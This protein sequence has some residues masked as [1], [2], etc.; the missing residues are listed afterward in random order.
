MKLKQQATESRTLNLA[1]VFG[2]I[3]N[4]LNN[5]RDQ[6]NAV[7]AN[8]NHGSNIAENFQMVANTLSASRNQDAPTQ[9]RQAAQVLQQNGRGG[10]ANLYAGGLLEAAQRLVGKNGI[11]LDDVLPL[12]QGLLSGVQGQTQAQPG[13]GTLLDTLLPAIMGYASARNNGTDNQSAISNALNAALHGSQQTYPQPSPF[14]NRTQQAQLPRR[15]PGAA[16]AHSLLEGLFNSIR[17]L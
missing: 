7:D 14:G 17:N 1:D 3:A 11:G 16:S 13:Q 12:L 2:S 4:Q 6:I 15:D 9:L 10:T 5:D 8:G